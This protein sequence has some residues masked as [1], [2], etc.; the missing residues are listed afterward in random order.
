[1][2]NRNKR[3]RKIL[4]KQF[5]IKEY[6]KNK[7]STPIIAKQTNCNSL[8]VRN[9]LKKYNIKVRTPEESNIKWDK[10]LTKKFLIKHYV[11]NKNSVYQIEEKIHGSRETIRGYLIKFN[12]TRRKRNP[13]WRLLA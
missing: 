4:T 2:K 5:L 3:I 7:K 11:K 8:T 9:R 12:I 13:I 10:L 1:M 6:V